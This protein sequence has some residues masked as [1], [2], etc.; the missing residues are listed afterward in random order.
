LPHQ[1]VH[2]PTKPDS[3]ATSLLLLIPENQWHQ[4]AQCY[5]DYTGWWLV[6]IWIISHK[7][8]IFTFHFLNLQF[9]LSTW[10]TALF[11][12]IHNLPNVQTFQDMFLSSSEERK[13]KKTL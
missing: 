2:T 8:S 1:I 9:I 12:D 13:A 4:L 6:I 11:R 10:S 5:K 3:S 7:I